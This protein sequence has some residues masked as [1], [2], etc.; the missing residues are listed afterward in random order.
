MFVVIVYRAMGG[1]SSSAAR[2]EEIEKLD[3]K[4]RDLKSLLLQR[5]SEITILVNMVKQG[6]TERDVQ[7]LPRPDTG[8]SGVS[9]AMG[10]ST[11]G[12]STQASGKIR[13]TDSSGRSCE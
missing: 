13:R 1:P 6:K 11:M 5:D 4:V 8:A 7:E 9:N 2:S 3:K 10:M 12:T